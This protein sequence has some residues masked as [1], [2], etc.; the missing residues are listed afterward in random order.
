MLHNYEYYKGGNLD[1]EYVRD[2]E[3][4]F[5]FGFW[6]KSCIDSAWGTVIE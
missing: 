3:D 6:F 1:V 4:V 5:I 2:S